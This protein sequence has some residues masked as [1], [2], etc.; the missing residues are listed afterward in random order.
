MPRGNL[1]LRRERAP[2]DCNKIVCIPRSRDGA[3]QRNFRVRTSLIVSH[4]L[5]IISAQQKGGQTVKLLR[6]RS[7]TGKFT[8]NALMRFGD[9]ARALEDQGLR[10]MKGGKIRAAARVIG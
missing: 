9:F 5:E 6:S 8:V 2:N 4:G 10:R 3:V 1:R 7:Q